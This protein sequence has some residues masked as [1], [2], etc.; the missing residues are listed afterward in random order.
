FVVVS[1]PHPLVCVHVGTSRQRVVFRVI[2]SD[3]NSLLCSTM[4]GG[5]LSPPLPLRSHD[6]H[7]NH[8]KLLPLQSST[9]QLQLA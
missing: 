2:W 7:D 8:R 6:Y 4:D 3:G 1:S 5:T 9:R